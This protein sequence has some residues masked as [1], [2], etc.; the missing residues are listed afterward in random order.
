MNGEHKEM[1]LL[2][3]YFLR[4]QLVANLQFI[5]IEALA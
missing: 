1:Y 3:H 5:K 2:D 4:F